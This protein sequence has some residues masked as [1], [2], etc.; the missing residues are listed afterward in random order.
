MIIYQSL[1]MSPVSR[2]DRLD[3]LSLHVNFC[4]M[5]LSNS[6]LERLVPGIPSTGTSVHGE[7]DEHSGPELGTLYYQCKAAR[8]ASVTETIVSLA[9]DDT[10]GSIYRL[11]LERI[12]YF[13][14][15][16]A[17]GMTEQ[18]FHGSRY[19]R[20]PCEITQPINQFLL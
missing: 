3:P 15:K 1:K 16:T 9:Q 10:F 8:D 13:Y 5:S 7:M 4:L 6:R 18:T 17:R 2:L 12:G 20:G 19:R 11:P 14:R